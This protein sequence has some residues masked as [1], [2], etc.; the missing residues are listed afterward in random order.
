VTKWSEPALLSVLKK[1]LELE[2]QSK[3]T[4]Y[5]T[6]TGIGQL[7]AGIGLSKVA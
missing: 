7:I 4:G 1:F 5:D 2:S 3:K 6:E